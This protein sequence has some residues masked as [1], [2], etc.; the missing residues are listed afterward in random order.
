M[1]FVARIE[2]VAEQP[3]PVKQVNLAHSRHAHHGKQLI[4]LE[5][6]TGFFVG[7]ARGTLGRGLAQLHEA[8][9][10]GPFAPSWLDVSFAQQHPVAQHRHGVLGDQRLGAVQQGLALE[11]ALVHVGHP[12]VVDLAGQLDELLRLGGVKV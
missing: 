6:R 9:G 3:G 10:Q 8:R 2:P 7:F 11:A 1:R 12:G 4:Q 5:L